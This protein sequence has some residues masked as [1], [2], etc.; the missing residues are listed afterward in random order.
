MSRYA[1]R[2]IDFTVNLPD[3]LVALMWVAPAAVFGWAIVRHPMLAVA[4]VGIL[5]SVPLVLSARVR[6]MVVVFGAVTVFQ[7]SDELTAPKLLYLFALAVSFGAALVR[8]PSLLNTPGFHDLAPMLR[9]SV[10]MFGLIAFSLPVSTLGGVPQTAWLRDVAPYVMVAC[11][12]VFALDAQASMSKVALQRLLVVG[13]T[14]GAL[15][16]TIRWLTNRQIADLSF[17]PVGLPTMLL[18]SVVFAYGISVLLHGD[19]RRVIWGVFTAL[20]L[21]M[22]LSTGT[23]STLVLL[24]APLAIVVWTPRRRLQRSVRL[25]AA[26]PF[27]ALLVFAASQGV[28]RVTDADRGALAARAR[29]LFSTGE[30]TRDRSYLDRLS[31]TSVSWELFRSSPVAGVGPGT[32]IKWA[33]SFGRPKESTVVD[34]PVSF[35]AKFGLVGLAVAGFAVVGYLATLR[36][37]R[38]RTGLP[39]VVQLA[40]VGFGAVVFS[41]SLLLNTFEDKGLAMGLILLLA[42]AAREARD[43]AEEHVAGRDTDLR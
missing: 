5:A 22:L 42:L 4:P 36:R 14:L 28:V 32:P 26:L 24:A 13:G 41:L 37:F 34:S 23:R 9:A 18:G 33:D 21:A 2:V 30:G 17:V 38:R 31:Q 8:L 40:L 29:L 43:A 15:G 6:V 25:A 20:V 27:V 7:S 1:Y 39:T 35:A 10:L 11:A 12:P 3:W 16:F 19:R